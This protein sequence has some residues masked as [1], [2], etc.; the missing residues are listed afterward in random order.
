MGRS[1]SAILGIV[2][3]AVVSS[4]AAPTRKLVLEEQ[5]I[6][7]K[8]R[9]PQLVLI[10]ADQRPRFDAIVVQSAQ[11]EESV[12]RAVDQSVIEKDPNDAPFRFFDKRI[13]G[14]VP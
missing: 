2:A 13:I 11:S 12:A 5:R 10:K 3:L 8:I 4:P 6:E 14:I 9:R 7:G 1:V